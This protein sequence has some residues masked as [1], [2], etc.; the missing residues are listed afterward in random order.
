MVIFDQK[1]LNPDWAIGEVPGTFYSLSRSG[2]MDTELFEEWFKN[3]F[4]R[5][6]PPA[7]PL[8]LLLDGHSSHYQPD[9][10]QAAAAEGVIMFCLPPHTTHILQPLDNCAFGSLKRQWG[11]ECHQFCTNKPGKVVNRYNF[12]SIFNSAC[13]KGMSMSNIIASFRAAGIFPLNRKAVLSQLPGTSKDAD[14]SHHHLLPFVSF[15]TLRRTGHS[16]SPRTAD[17]P[18]D[19]VQHPARHNPK[20]CSEHRDSKPHAFTSAQ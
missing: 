15:C 11:E 10:V 13:L 1:L 4:L 8:L 14:A 5:H 2:W 7:R 20:P 18:T 16:T 3:H 6:A 12:S 9:L 19:A 17:L